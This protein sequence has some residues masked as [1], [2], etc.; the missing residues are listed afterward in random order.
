MLEWQT[1]GDI[2]GPVPV[3]LCLRHCAFCYGVSVLLQVEYQNKLLSS[4]VYVPQFL[5]RFESLSIIL[6]HI[7]N[8]LYLVHEVWEIG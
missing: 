7:T 8:S 2:Y 5:C 1:R 4:T 6:I 3:S